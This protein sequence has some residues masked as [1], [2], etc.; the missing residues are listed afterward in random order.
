MWK[1]PSQPREPIAPPSTRT[2]QRPPACRR[3]S[4]RL[5]A[6]ASLVALV[7]TACGASS[8]TPST[9]APAGGGPS[10]LPSS[11]VPS[12]AV[13]SPADPSPAGAAGLLLEVTT[14][15]GFINP[16][17]TIG[18]LP[19]LV[20]ETDGT[21]YTPSRDS[22]P[23]LA[24]AITVRDVG[25][26]GAGAIT[27][28]IRAAGLDTEG[29]GGIMADT[30]AAVF[31][32][33]LGGAEMVSRFAGGGGPGPGVPGGHGGPGASADPSSPG[34][35]AFDLLARLTDP[36][37]DWAGSTGSQAAYVPVGYRIFVAPTADAASA[38]IPWP[39]AGTPAEFGAPA[40]VD[41][42]VDGLRSGV[43]LAADAGPLAPLLGAEPGSP[44]TAGGKTWN[45]WVRPL[46]PHELGG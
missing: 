8:G 17:A 46:F 41:H 19:A 39:L 45:V 23:A 7:A 20:V 36:T 29:S 27:D 44:V 34:A 22:A 9:P 38:G 16:A 28:A 2:W 4:A 15:G 11:A 31:T 21:I 6:A 43:V 13:P 37:V 12:S 35:A 40:A 33:D 32:V 42:G 26:A 1:R 25:A 5:A 3:T 10:A 14:E 24:P 18:A 30:G